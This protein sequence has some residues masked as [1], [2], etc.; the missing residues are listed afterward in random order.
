MMFFQ[1]IKKR[2]A[3]TSL[4]VPET[5]MQKQIV[6]YLRTLVFSV[7]GFEEDQC[8]LRASALTLYTL[9]SVVPV[10]AMAFGIAKGFGFEKMLEQQLLENIPGQE[11]GILYII[12]FARKLLENTQGG[13]VAGIGVI[14]LFWSVMKVLGNIE[15][16]FNH[17][18]KVR[19]SRNFIRKFSD[20]LSIMLI[21]PVLVISASSVSVFISVR[22]RD[23]TENTELLEVFSPFILSTLKLSPYVIIWI[24]FSFI[25]IFMP[26]TRVTFWSGAF[27]G[28]LAGTI[29]QLVQA[30][31]IYF[32]VK[33]SNYNAIYGSFAALPFFVMWLQLSWFVVLFGAELSFFHQHRKTWHSYQYYERLS[34]YLRKLLA[35]HIAH[36]LIKNF[37]QGHPPLST[38]QLTRQTQLSFALIQKSLDLLLESGIILKTPV[39]G[40]RDMA[41]QPAK[42]PELLSIQN[43][44]TSLERRGNEDPQILQTYH[45]DQIVKLL[46]QFDAALEQHPAN[47]LLK[48]VPLN[49]LSL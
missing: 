15:S 11:E 18:W 42:P 8:A 19:E 14:M 2:F 10:A 20:Y 1:L 47:V 21:A 7:R 33:I 28:V 12:D 48:D 35:L 36:I 6:E 27:A 43:V 46:E 31:Y 49:E 37:A 24:L 30:G 38:E 25:Y 22:V 39:Q 29:Y 5:W 41:Y 45:I 17:I 16:S 34:P 26:N 40:E 13:L 32:Q 4:F 44:L 9:L 23:I 3:L